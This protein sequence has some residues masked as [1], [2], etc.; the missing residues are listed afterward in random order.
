MVKE[1]RYW[2]HVVFT[3]L[4]VSTIFVGSCKRDEVVEWDIVLPPT[5]IL[6]NDQSW[7]VVI[8]SYLKVTEEMDKN[9]IVVATLRKGA[10]LEILSSRVDRETSQLWYRVKGDNLEGWVENI[11]VKQFENREQAETASR[12]R[13]REQN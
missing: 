1:N 6:S 3:G 9:S 11:S 2:R 5:P 12:E 7:A 4:L 13:D 10:V 8:D